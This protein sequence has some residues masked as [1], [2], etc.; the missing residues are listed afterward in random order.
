[1]VALRFLVIFFLVWIVVTGRSLLELFIWSSSDEIIVLYAS[2]LA[3]GSIQPSSNVLTIAHSCQSRLVKLSVL[4]LYEP[5]LFLKKFIIL[6]S[7]LS[8]EL[9]LR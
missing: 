1:L 7:R 2:L 6:L 4:I 9:H 5:L 8:F 3:L